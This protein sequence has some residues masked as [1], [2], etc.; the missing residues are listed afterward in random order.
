MAAWS[1]IVDDFLKTQNLVWLP[2]P[3][4][5]P[6]T[7]DEPPPPGFSEAGEKT[8][9]DYLALGPHK[10]FAMS[11]HRDGFSAAQMTVE[12]AKSKALDSCRHAAPKGEKC[13]VVSIDGAGQDEK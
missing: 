4:P 11:E 2:E 6:K 13:A 9:R 3:L 8:F 12:M 1:A 10:A 7:R 5:P